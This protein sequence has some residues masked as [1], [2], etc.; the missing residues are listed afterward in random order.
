MQ[1]IRV[2]PRGYTRKIMISYNELNNFLL[3]IPLFFEFKKC[4]IEKNRTTHLSSV[5]FKLAIK[6]PKYLQTDKNQIYKFLSE[7]V[8]L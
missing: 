4:E 1:I 6:S 2:Y 5:I 3:L 8:P 7:A